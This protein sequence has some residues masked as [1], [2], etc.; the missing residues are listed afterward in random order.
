MSASTEP[1]GIHNGL[2]VYQR[3]QGHPL[4]ALPYP[5]ASGGVR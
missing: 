1:V 4:L 2:V 5:H 3:S